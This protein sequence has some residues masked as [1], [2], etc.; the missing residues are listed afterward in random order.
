MEEMLNWIEEIGGQVNRLEVW[1]LL[2]VGLL[3][4]VIVSLLCAWSW[5]RFFRRRL[6]EMQEELTSHKWKTGEC[7]AKVDGGMAESR[8][9]IRDCLR[10]AL[11][12]GKEARVLDEG[13]VDRSLESLNEGCQ[14]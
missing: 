6:A 9:R 14:E 7:F 4:G 5:I 8:D 1:M 3:F 13:L 10:I 2:V 11:M 12:I